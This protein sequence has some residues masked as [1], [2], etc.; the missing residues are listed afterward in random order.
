MVCGELCGVL[1][2]L[3]LVGYL[4]GYMDWVYLYLCSCWLVD[5]F[6]WFDCGLFVWLGLIV[7]MCVWLLGG[8]GLWSDL[9]CVIGCYVFV[10]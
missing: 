3:C 9:F 7:V 8:L 5:W 6:V 10:L 4:I 2:L 1:R